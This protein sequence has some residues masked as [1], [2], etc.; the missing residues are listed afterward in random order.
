MIYERVSPESPIQQGDLFRCVPRVEMSLAQIP[1]IDGL[2]TRQTSW[3]ELV[4]SSSVGQFPENA[5]PVAAVLAIKPVL[6]IAIT[7]NCDAA[8][9]RDLCLCQVDKFLTV[10]G[11][12]EAPQNSKKWQSLIIRMMRTNPKFFYLPEDSVFGI[13]E[14]MAADFRVIIRVA[15]E[16]LEAMRADY[17]IARLKPLATEHFRESL[18]FFF[19]RYAFNEWYPLTPDEFQ[20][21]KGESQEP[22]DP[23][24]WQKPPESTPQSDA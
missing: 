5:Q 6:A 13:N 22:V 17:R 15:R 18:S 1:V 11:Q 24:A 19:R 12:K 2:Q 20:A 8:R 21:Y 23:Y 7:Q 4:K 9:A 16:D 14:R 10:V 3:R